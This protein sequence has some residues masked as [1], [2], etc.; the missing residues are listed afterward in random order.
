MQ[1][2][3]TIKAV[4]VKS[5]VKKNKEGEI[6]DRKKVL[7]LRIESENEAMFNELSDLQTRDCEIA[8]TY[9]PTIVSNSSE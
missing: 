9:N 4:S 1:I 6:E 7:I 5:I 3:G 2:I 8:I